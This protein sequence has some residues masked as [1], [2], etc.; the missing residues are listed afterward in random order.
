MIRII[1]MMMLM[2][3][4]P[5]V[6]GIE[7]SQYAAVRVQKAHKL[8]EDQQFEQAIILLKSI[9]TSR[10]YDKAFIDRMLAVFYWQDGNNG[11]AIH[12][13]AT[14]IESGWLKGEQAWVSQRM[15][16]DL[17]LN[18][19]QFALA[20]KYYYSL[21]DEVPKTQVISDLWLRI[22]QSHYQLEQW[23]EVTVAVNH[24]LKPETR[25]RLT[26]LSLKLGA[27][28]ELKQWRQAIGSLEMLIDLQPK[29]LKWWRQMVSIQLHVGQ[30]QKA[31]DTLALAKLQGLDLTPTDQRLLAQMYA[32]QGIAE[33]AALE[34]SEL[35]E[36]NNDAQH[37]AEQATYWQLAKEWD[38]A[39][40]VWKQAAGHDAQY[41]W[42][43]AQ[44]LVQQSDY[45]NALN[46]LDQV[47]GRKADVALAKTQ[48]LYKLNRLDKALS[49]A[50]ISESIEPSNQAKS[51][52]KYLYQ[53]KRAKSETSISG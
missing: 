45:L 9:E 7:L 16:A 31:L 6:F 28:L 21:V 51:W 2:L 39:L 13:M 23:E 24:Y 34:M 19:R 1:A 52:I 11:Q 53:I 42:N 41:L 30:D 18:D 48:V 47:Q 20:L 8:G 26:P 14:A 36:A 4:S 35:E 32:K 17:Y 5:M 37:L 22:A 27:E 12:Y 46:I 3:S 29:Q 43:V 50:K 33:R 25:D 38:K 40:I 44:L 49:Q 15:L 10:G